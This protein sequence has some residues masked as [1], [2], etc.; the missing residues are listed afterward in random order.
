MKIAEFSV[1]NGQFTFIMFLAVMALGIG[2]LLNMPRAEDPKFEAPGF[3]II[4]VYPGAGPAEMEDKVTD[5]V[6]AK[7]G[8]LENIDR[9]RSYS[10]NGLSVV[11]LEFKHGQDP[12]KKYEEVIREINAIRPELPPD[13]YRTEVQRF[14]AA[15]VAMMQMAI[16]SENASWQQ[17]RDEAERLEER[18][19]KIAGLKGADVYG[20]P[21]RE[22]RIS[23]NLPKMAAEGIPLSR[24]LGALQ[25]ENISIPGGA[26]DAGS[27]QF[28]VETS[29]DYQNIDEVRQTIVFANGGKIIYLQDLATVEFAYEEPRHMARLNGARS[30]FVTA[31]MKNGQNITVVGQQV[32]QTLEAFRE[33][34][35]ANMDFQK[36]FDQNDSVH[37]RLTRFSKDFAIAILLVLL[38]LLPLGTRASIVVMISIPLSISIGLFAL[39][40]LGYSLNQLSIVGLIIALGILVDDS[41]VV[42]EN[43]ERWLREGHSRR[44]AAILATRQIGLAVL[45]CTAT[46]ILAFLPLVFLPEAAGDFIRSLPMA[47]VTTV[48]AS[49]FVSLTIVPF[50]GSR[51]LAEHHDPRGNIFLRGLK[52]AISKS[53]ARLLHVGLRYPGWTMLASAAI[54]IGVLSLVGRAGFAVFPASERPM[55]YI[56]VETAPGTSFTE[57]DRVVRMVDSVLAGYMDEELRRSAMGGVKINLAEGQEGETTVSLPHSVYPGHG[58]PARIISYASNV[59]R[60]NPRMYYNVIPRNES[61][62]YGQIL[63]QLQERTPP[64][65]KIALID[66]LRETFKNVPGAVINVKNFEQGPPIEAPVAIRVFGENLDSLR[67][68]AGQVENMVA[69]LEGTIYVDNPIASIKTDLRV[70]INKD[71]ATSLGIPIAE[72]DRMVR[73]GIAGLNAGNFSTPDGDEYN[74]TVTLPK[75]KVFADLNVFKNLYVNSLSGAS[76]PMSQVAELEFSR[77]PNTITHYDKDRYTLVSAFVRSGHLAQTINAKVQENL[78]KMDFPKG[79]HYVIA[80]EVETSQRSFGGMGTIIMITIFGL[81][82]VLILE[83]KTFR[84]TIIVLSVIPLGIIGAVL[85]LLATG[86]PFSFT[87]AVGLIALMGIEV[88]NSILLVDFTNQLRKE[89]RGL[90]EAIQEAG[91]IRFVP[92]LLTSLTAIGGLM[93]LAI[94]ENPLYSPLAYVLIGGLISSTLLS[95]IVTPVL[96]KLLAPKLG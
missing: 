27:R 6:E 91:E 38:T 83:F 36:V 76:V 63:V 84:S 12:D 79:Y 49:L 32:N 14:S 50:L 30:V 58:A 3:T 7:L 72:I 71:K 64:P 22:V 43:I 44:D 75:D 17:L 62:D 52:W 25:S 92:I 61:P 21:K 23:L 56:D 31:R 90:D 57:T 89:G 73:L 33:D 70:K 80:G 78:E 15:D 88:K 65:V 69:G 19:E 66:E 51:I 74:L 96:Y 87:V 13:M 60:G 93:P 54:F 82:A 85:A 45:G 39:D 20:F 81:L 10:A 1:K 41:I 77:S 46:L 86:Y 24:V 34:L 8:A 47:V 29:G 2:S 11:T 68:V 95:R 28:F 55:F 67:K 35:P 16:I 4:M 48:I 42:V 59:G 26:I 94:E 9:M 40:Q 5:K 53:Y 18:L 37:K